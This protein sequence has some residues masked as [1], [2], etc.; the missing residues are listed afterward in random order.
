MKNR[1]LFLATSL[2]TFFLSSM[3][4]GESHYIVSEE[5]YKVLLARGITT[6]KPGDW[7]SH[8]VISESCVGERGRRTVESLEKIYG[9]F[10]WDTRFANA[11]STFPYK[12]QFIEIDGEPYEGPEHYFQLMKADNPTDAI[13]KKFLDAHDPDKHY[14]IGRYE[15]TMRGD[16][17]SVVKAPHQHIIEGLF[18][19][20]D[21]LKD[22][23]MQK[24]LWA[25][26]QAP[27]LKTLL[28]STG[29][30]RL[31]QLKTEDGYWGT[32]ANNLGQNKLGAFL[33]RV[34]TKLQSTDLS[35]SRMLFASMM[36]EKAEER[37]GRLDLSDMSLRDDKAFELANLIVRGKV[38]SLDLSR[39]KITDKGARVLLAA[40]FYS[41]TLEEL[42]LD[43]QENPID[44]L[45]LE[46]IRLR[47]LQYKNLMMSFT[48]T[49]APNMTMSFID[50]NF[51]NSKIHFIVYGTTKKSEPE[52]I[53]AG[54]VVKLGPE[55]SVYLT[56]SDMTDIL[57]SLVTKHENATNGRY[58]IGGT[59]IGFAIKAINRI[60]TNQPFNLAN[61]ED[62]QEL[63][64]FLNCA[65][66]LL[67][68]N[69]QMRSELRFHMTV[70]NGNNIYQVRENVDGNVFYC[71]EIVRFWGYTNAN[72]LLILDGLEDAYQKLR[73]NFSALVL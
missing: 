8:A 49:P 51:T 43:D 15:V 13:K 32:G 44:P 17:N 10:V 55:L 27:E 62:E 2:I 11:H 65:A 71:P 7:A 48:Q 5:V 25:K 60:N 19:E 37:N 6:Y 4:N 40:T 67:K 29:N 26:F 45:I 23:V 66:A 42:K 54:K 50:G 61:K 46:A 20:G 1:K 41:H 73:D 36:K 33:E 39:N 3:V 35:S 22:V 63:A 12:E 70:A 16:W 21:T 58:A 30:K 38:I 52:S 14:L 47:L 34:R 28:L 53:D 18:E 68:I 9:D 64:G 59:N 69:A 24:A 56:A 72:E 31:V 57:E